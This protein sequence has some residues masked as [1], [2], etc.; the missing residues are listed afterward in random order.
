M[1]QLAGGKWSYKQRE[2]HMQAITTSLGKHIT[3]LSQCELRG[4][5]ASGA[6]IRAFCPV[7][8]SD[9]QR[10]LSICKSNGWGHCFNAAC[11]ATVL[12]AEWNPTLSAHLLHHDGP[13]FFSSTSHNE[14]LAERLPLALQ[15]VL[16]HLPPETEPWQRDELCMLDKLDEQLPTMLLQTQCAQS[17]LEGRGISL[18]TALETGAGYLGPE[19]IHQEPQAHPLMRRWT[20]RIIFPLRSPFGT[21]YIGRALWRWKPGMDEQAHKELLERMDGP[22]RWIKTNPAGWFC[23]EFDHLASNIVIVEGAFDRLTLLAAGFADTEVVAL[24]GT[25]MQISWLP[26]QVRHITLALD[27]DEGG[28]AATQ[29]L[30]EQL[31][32]EGFSVKICP[33][34][35]DCLGKD[36][37]ERWRNSG[38]RAIL[39]LQERY[40]A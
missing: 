28:T 10:S 17:Y 35:Q 38:Y 3:V 6:Y 2:G 30:T 39:P 20:A 1:W 36:W 4:P 12:V 5:R 13:F 24:T 18:A 9:H 31:R 22:R 25:T 29:R 26:P 7:H 19:Y 34:P 40:L 11:A 32:H 37:N 8:G 33:T 15:P 14:P 27:G 23:C 16:L 21:G